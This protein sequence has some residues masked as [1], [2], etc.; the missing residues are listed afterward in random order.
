MNRKVFLAGATGVIGTAL[1][2]L[3]IDAGYTVYGG[4]RRPERA[5]SLEAAGAVP[6]V[7]DVFDRDALAAALAHS[8]G[9]IYNIAED[10]AEVSSDKARRELGWRPDMRAS[11]ETR[12]RA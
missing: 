8:P 3:L 11:K 4:T 1:V 5:A 10:R 2:P 12:A 9:G 7:V 6:V